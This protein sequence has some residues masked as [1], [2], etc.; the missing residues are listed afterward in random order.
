MRNFLP[1]AHH[2]AGAAEIRPDMR[3]R[4]AADV[5]LNSRTF[6]SPNGEY[7]AFGVATS[8]RRR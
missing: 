6:T 3:F 5:Y 8:D 4:E 1:V 7:R 2:P